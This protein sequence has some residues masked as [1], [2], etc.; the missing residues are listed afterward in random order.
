MRGGQMRM[1]NDSAQIMREKMTVESCLE[2]LRLHEERMK[3]LEAENKW[4]LEYYN[5][6]EA[7]DSVGLFAATDGEIHR[8]ILA[9]K[10]LKEVEDE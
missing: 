7:V 5:A 8:V 3:E 10:A 6:R 9:R 1:M 4:L 2:A